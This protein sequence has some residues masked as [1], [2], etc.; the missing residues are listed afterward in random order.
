MRNIKHSLRAFTLIELLVVI[1][2]IAI[3]ASLALPAITGALTKGQIA[4][5]S[6]NARQIYIAQLSMVTD[7]IPSADTN[8]A[9][10]AEMG[11]TWSTWATALVGGKY[12]STND[13]NKML[14]VPSLVRP[15]ATAITAPT[16]SA[17]NVYNVSDT[18]NLSHVFIT[19]ANFTNGQPLDPTA[20]PFGDKGF[21]VVRKD[22]SASTYT[23]SQA[24]NTNLLPPID[25]TATILK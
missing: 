5:A 1:S 20:K 14:G 10:P 12:L 19:T 11:G 16:P 9:W 15:P 13:F 7:G 25:F 3:L 17:F 6:S 21:A 23:V 8:L 4:Q 22:G 24:T 18:N 2:I